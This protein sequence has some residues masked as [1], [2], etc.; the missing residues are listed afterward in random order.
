[1][2]IKHVHKANLVLTFRLNVVD[3]VTGTSLSYTVVGWCEGAG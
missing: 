2:H 3:V 1:M